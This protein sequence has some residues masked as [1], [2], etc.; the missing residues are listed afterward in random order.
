MSEAMLEQKLKAILHS[1]PVMMQVLQGTRDLQLPD[2]RVFSGAV[3]QRVWNHQ[4]GRAVDYGIKDYDIGYF[5]PDT[6][7]DAEDVWIKRFAAHFEGPLSEQVEVRNQARVH[8]W[9]PEKYGQPY[10]PLT[11]TDEAM[12]RFVAPCFAVGVRLE[13]DGEISVAAPFGLEDMFN[14]TIRPTPERPV[15]KDWD[16]IITKLQ[17]R[18][19]ELK[20]MNP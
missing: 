1:D 12:A 11:H 18:W 14:L 5:D 19:P 7:W 2:W 20:V 3:Y 13:N 17:A 16:K 6:S 4:T 10:T 15:A 8:L 9:F